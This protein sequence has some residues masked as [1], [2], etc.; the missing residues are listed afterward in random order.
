MPSRYPHGRY[1]LG[2]SARLVRT[3][4]LVVGVASAATAQDATRPRPTDPGITTLGVD[5]SRV[6]FVEALDPWQFASASVSHRTERGS[7]IGRLNYANRFGSN[8]T[9]FE[10][11]AYP[12]L[13]S[14]IYAYMSAGYSGSGIF[15]T[16]RSG[17]ELFTSLPDAWEASLGYRQLRFSGV[18]TTLFTGAVGRYI[19]NSWLSLRPYMHS[20]S[21][22]TSASLSLT[23]RTYNA[24]GDHFLGARVSF[25]NAP[26]DLAS[27][28]A[29]SVARLR[30]FSASLQGS[31]DLTSAL[32]GTWSLGYENEELTATRTRRSISTSVGVRMRL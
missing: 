2:V 16:W 8:G 28:D 32:L 27:V 10:V 3:L 11:D 31:G 25:G 4:S 6:T 1:A 14:S 12:R 7:L 18:P 30:D 29:A 19:G 26:P 22:G 17:G 23:G 21:S 13:T 9:Q 20:S 5:Y 15:P 24:D